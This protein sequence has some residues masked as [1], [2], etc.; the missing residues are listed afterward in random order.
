MNI[1]E[2]T[3]SE[4]TFPGVNSSLPDIMA[5]KQHEDVETPPSSGD[6]EEERRPTPDEIAQLQA[7]VREHGWY[8][9][10]EHGFFTREAVRCLR[11][12]AST[13]ATAVATADDGVPAVG[14]CV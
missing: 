10:R 6:E 2:G 1:L 9:A 4:T 13:T 5:I 8:A 7:V 11:M 12:S 3:Q 14:E